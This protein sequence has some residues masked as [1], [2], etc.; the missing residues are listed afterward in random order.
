MAKGLIVFFLLSQTFIF[1]QKTLVIQ[2]ERPGKVKEKVFYQNDFISL[3]L[4]NGRSSG[5]L[6]A[7]GDSSILLKNGSHVDTIALKSVKAVIFNRSNHIID[8][9]AQAFV[10]AGILVIGLDATNNLIQS[11]SP[12]FKPR[13]LIVGSSLAIAGVL[14][15]LYERKI[16]RLGKRKK[17]K[18]VDLRPY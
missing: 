16:V 15:K 1:G 2:I 14:I 10:I 5:N 9:F 11:E 17:L 13:I 6:L 7:I 18:T 4:K 8:A 12:I 3:K